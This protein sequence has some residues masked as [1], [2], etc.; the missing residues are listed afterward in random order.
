MFHIVTLVTRR[1]IWGLIWD[2]VKV[3]HCYFQASD[4]GAQTRPLQYVLK[5]GENYTILID[6]SFAV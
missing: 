3:C 5:D 2:R 1:T 4:L 6:A